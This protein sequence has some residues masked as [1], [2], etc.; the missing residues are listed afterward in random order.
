MAPKRHRPAI[1]LLVKYLAVLRHFGLKPGD[2]E[3]DHD[4]PLALRE[5]DEAS[6]TY[7]PPANDPDRI[8]MLLKADHRAK[9]HH[10]RGPHTTIGSDQHA[11]HKAKPE[12]AAKFQVNKPPLA[13]PA[14]G[15]AH[16]RCGR[17]GQYQD[18]CSCPPAQ[19][20]TSFRRKTA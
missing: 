8:V 10:P 15:P 16:V 5:Y 9:T 12:Q 4:P 1:P 11:I 6:R 14:T 18:E 2:I 13:L 7:S 20:R 3:F 17:C 19:A